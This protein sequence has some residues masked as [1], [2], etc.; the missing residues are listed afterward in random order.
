MKDVCMKKIVALLFICITGTGLIAPSCAF[1][2]DDK[3]LTELGKRKRDTTEQDTNKKRKE[4]QIQEKQIEEKKTIEVEGDCPICQEEL[5]KYPTTALHSTPTSTNAV[6]HVLHTHCLIQYLRENGGKKYL[7]Q[8]LA[9]IDYNPTNDEIEDE[10]NEF[11]A[12]DDTIEQDLGMNADFDEELT[13]PMKCPIC[14]APFTITYGEL[15]KNYRIYLNNLNLKERFLQLDELPIEYAFQTLK[16]YKQ[17]GNDARLQIC[18]IV[19]S[20]RILQKF[21]IKK[22]D[23]WINAT[24]KEGG[25]WAGNKYLDD[26]HERAIRIAVELLQDK[27]ITPEFVRLMI[28][29]EYF[30][31]TEEI[32]KYFKY[33]LDS[34]VLLMPAGAFCGKRER[35][36]T[37]IDLLVQ[38]T[39][40]KNTPPE[41]IASIQNRA[42]VRMAEVCL[43]RF[44][45]EAQKAYFSELLKRASSPADKLYV[46]NKLLPIL[47]TELGL[48]FFTDNTEY[49]KLNL[50]TKIRLF[51][52]LVKELTDLKGEEYIKATI[53]KIYGDLLKEKKITKRCRAFSQAFKQILKN[54]QRLLLTML[55]GCDNPEKA[56]KLLGKKYQENNAI[57]I[58]VFKVLLNRINSCYTRDNGAI[59][60]IYS[61]LYH[62]SATNKNAGNVFYEVALR[63]CCIQ[64]KRSTTPLERDKYRMDLFDLIIY[65]VKPTTLEDREALFVATANAMETSKALQ[66]FILKYFNKYFDKKKELLLY[67][68]A[69]PNSLNPLRNK[70]VKTTLEGAVPQNYFTGLQN[71]T[72]PAEQLETFKKLWPELKSTERYPGLLL[73]LTHLHP[74]NRKQILKIAPLKD[75]FGACTGTERFGCLAA[76]C[77]LLGKEQTT[78]IIDNALACCNSDNEKQVIFFAR[79]WINKAI[80]RNQLGTIIV[81]RPLSPQQQLNNQPTLPNTQGH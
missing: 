39:L 20:A 27:P 22:A 40:P 41:K 47:P 74:D 4:E 1:G 29:K 32:E 7:C 71:Y 31:K 81:V 21:A 54:D 11:E 59:N 53:Q 52:L 57:Q 58:I 18:S 5:K 26:C 66:D 61:I 70:M 76:L 77:R 30:Q 79:D 43:S 13:P 33:A 64:R 67:Y 19:E 62:C 42:L 2:A 16:Y 65:S 56:G 72:S 49:E 48:N 51:P 73:A 25:L 23:I 12:A 68:F 63:D 36:L 37:D 28:L 75:W 24:E 6:E 3:E 78:L 10:D 69:N 14:R 9:Q 46:I 44:T 45:K 15:R 34:N 80:E 38:K 60:Y 8:G 55:I 35:A 17:L 50:K